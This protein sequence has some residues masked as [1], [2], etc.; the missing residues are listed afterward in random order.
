MG[1]RY[2]AVKGH[3]MRS[4]FIEKICYVSTYY[5]DIKISLNYIGWIT[6]LGL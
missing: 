2:I 4:I 1:M 5:I 3:I 6:K